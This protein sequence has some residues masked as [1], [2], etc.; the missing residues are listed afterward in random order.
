[1]NL[2]DATVCYNFDDDVVDECG[3]YDGS[4]QGGATYDVSSPFA[5]GKSVYFDGTN[6]YFDT[7]FQNMYVDKNW[8]ICFWTNT[9]GT[10]EQDYFFGSDDDGNITAMAWHGEFTDN[11]YKVYTMGN[12]DNDEIVGDFPETYLNS[13]KWKHVCVTSNGTGADSLE[14]YINATIV[15]TD[16]TADNDRQHTKLTVDLWFGALNRD[17][18]IINPLEMWLDDL[19]IWNNT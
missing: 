15:T 6:D 12:G 14:V 18:G 13:T 9:T 2:Y 3:G 8:T 7:N 5:S 10:T 1:L 11:D 16:T 4:L 19:L 17:D